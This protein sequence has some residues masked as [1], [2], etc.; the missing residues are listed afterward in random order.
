V[1]ASLIN[2]NNV[3]EIEDG[4]AALED[5]SNLCPA[6]GKQ[7]HSLRCEFPFQTQLDRIRFVENK[8]S[9]HASLP[10]WHKCQ[11]GTIRYTNCVATVLLRPRPHATRKPRAS[12]PAFCGGLFLCRQWTGAQSHQTVKRANPERRRC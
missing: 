6:L 7:R 5:A 9:Q 2:F 10:L 11:N 3:T 1:S 4:F 8:D 12:K